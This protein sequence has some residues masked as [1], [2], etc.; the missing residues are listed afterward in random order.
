MGN[1][2]QLV[3]NYVK[4]LSWIVFDVFKNYYTKIPI[5]LISGFIGVSLLAVT[6]LCF[7][8]FIRKLA[9]GEII[10][11]PLPFSTGELVIDHV[12]I[13]GISMVGFGM[14]LLLILSET[15]VYYSRKKTLD[16]SKYYAEFCSRR[17][18]ELI[19]GPM[20]TLGETKKDI[21]PDKLELLRAGTKYARICGIAL[22][23]IVDSIVPII[24]FL[25]S[26]GVMLYYNALLSASIIIIL[27]IYVVFQAH[28]SRQGSKSTTKS[29]QKSPLARKTY[30]ALI[31]YFLVENP[32]DRSA[33]NRI[34]DS[35]RKGAI[36]ESN[37]AYINRL[38]VIPFSRLVTGFFSAL[39]ISVLII[40]IVLSNAEQI[41]WNEIFT[42]LI[43]MRFMLVNLKL[44]FV[45]LTVINRA[46]TNLKKYIYLVNLLKPVPD[47]VLNPLSDYPVKK[48]NSVLPVSINQIRIGK[49]LVYSI[50]SDLSRSRFNILWFYK[51]LSGKQDKPVSLNFD[52]IQFV[53]S[54]SC[55]KGQTVQELF[56]KYKNHQLQI[57]NDNNL[58]DHLASSLPFEIN[59]RLT[60]Q[61]W[62]SMTKSDKYIMS[63]MSA[64]ISE[65][66]VLVLDS[67][68]FAGD[69]STLKSIMCSQT[70]KVVYIFHQSDNGFVGQLNEA[71]L[72]VINDYALLGVGDRQWYE[73]VRE[74]INVNS[75]ETNSAISPDDDLDLEDE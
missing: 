53:S 12:S 66:E 70:S 16:L 23:K 69:T 37:Q 28:V 73:T 57:G 54:R 59:S 40:G 3:R 39:I 48:Q 64:M 8:F 1:I 2:F 41:D 31:D 25:V 33:D 5:V 72:F 51:I 4:D 18:V 60:P 47:S 71:L 22:R 61:L 20:I 27:L 75:K 55:P 45:N 46:Y 26:L 63:L 35:F 52:N 67:N 38:A 43:P 49:G 74:N 50:V 62:N 65:S 11:I 42:Y 36:A 19:G 6:F 10:G 13:T 24:T 30:S 44:V 9:G 7:L 21:Y 15:A 58:T 14:F 17:I 32:D 68:D 29:E 34:N 56:T